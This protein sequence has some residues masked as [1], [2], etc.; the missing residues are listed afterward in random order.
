MQA[1][2]NA[3]ASRPSNST[4]PAGIAYPG[5]RRD[6]G[7]HVTRMRQNQQGIAIAQDYKRAAAGTGSVNAGETQ[8]QVQG[9]MRR[10]RYHVKCHARSCPY[11]RDPVSYRAGVWF[12]FVSF[13]LHLAVVLC[14]VDRC[15]GSWVL[16]ALFLLLRVTLTVV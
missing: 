3:T 7:Q 2:L 14:W 13:A 16:L 9:P 10:R 1:P 11:T 5:Q 6:E 12:D 8:V 4:S 15:F